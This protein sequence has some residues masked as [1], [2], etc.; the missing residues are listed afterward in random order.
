MGYKNI[1]EPV[2]VR[3][4]IN[5]ALTATATKITTLKTQGDIQRS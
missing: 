2:T 3:K 5:K 4:D 1:Y